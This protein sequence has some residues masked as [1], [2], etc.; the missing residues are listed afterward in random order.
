MAPGPALVESLVVA[1][2]LLVTFF[3]VAGLVLA[4]AVVFVDDLDL[5]GALAFARVFFAALVFEDAFAWVRVC[6]L[7]FFGA[8][9]FARVLFAALVFL[10]VVALALVDTLAFF[11]ALVFALLRG[12]LR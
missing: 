2:V 9:A 11:G 12:L 3:L 8:V 1:P 6:A 10:G 7:A 4:G 5:R